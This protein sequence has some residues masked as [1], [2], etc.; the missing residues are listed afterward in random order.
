MKNV[1]K[2]IKR[3]MKIPRKLCGIW[4][5]EK[6]MIMIMIIHKTIDFCETFS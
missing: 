3:K 1:G 4:C 5:K 6:K 2:M